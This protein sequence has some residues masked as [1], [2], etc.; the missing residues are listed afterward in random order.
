MKTV[1]TFLALLLLAPLPA[2]T[3]ETMPRTPSPE[4]ARVYILTPA[5]NTHH[6]SPVTIRF[7]LSVMGIAP[8]GVEYTDTGHHHLLINR[9]IPPLDE[10]M[11]TEKGLKHFGK[12]QTETILDL[13]PGTYTL[14]LILGDQFHIPHEPAV[15]SDRITIMVQ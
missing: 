15:I 3:E 7:G 2:S 9:K 8:A 14:Q 6:T 1:L 13:A 10:A 12:G 4:G 11:P 5:D